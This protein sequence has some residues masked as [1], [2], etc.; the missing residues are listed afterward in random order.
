VLVPGERLLR[1]G[2]VTLLALSLCWSALGRA[3]DAT[4]CTPVARIV[5]LQGTL[6]LQRAGQGG[7]SYV[8]AQARH[9]FVRK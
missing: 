3:E 4:R 2:A 7:A 6:Q 9:A 1:P 8:C 5:S